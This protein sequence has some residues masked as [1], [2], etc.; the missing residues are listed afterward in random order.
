M[1]S[2]RET[3]KTAIRQARLH[4]Y[5]DPIRRFY[6]SG[7]I[8]SQSLRL[9]DFLGIGAPKSGTTWLHHNL[10]AHPDLYLPEGKELHYFS[11]HQFRGLLWYARQFEDAGRRKC[12]E[13]TPGYAV[14]PQRDIERIARLIPRVKLLL[15]VRDPVDRAWSH[16][17]M[18]LSRETG[19]SLESITDDEFEAHFSGEHSTER[20]DYLRMIDSW[21]SV[22]SEDQIWIGSFD[23]LRDRPTDLLCDV[24]EFLGVS[25]DV[26]WSGFPHQKVID[27]GVHGTTDVIGKN[28]GP[29]MPEHLAVRLRRALGP[30]ID[31]FAQRYPDIGDRWRTT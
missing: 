23:V 4:L 2:A 30:Q 7:R 27:R 17:V 26:D 25:P 1:T 9:P 20:G 18:K 24:F 11:D 16:A 29:Q 31:A 12:G 5:A 15:L 8:S 6:E 28:R 3:A 21:T 14:L 22:F 19:R 13:I 10:A